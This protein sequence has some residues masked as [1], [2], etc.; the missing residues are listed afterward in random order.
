MNWTYYLAHV[1]S[2]VIY[3]VI[4]NDYMKGAPALT[5]K[6]GPAGVEGLLEYLYGTALHQQ[7]ESWAQEG[8]VG[9]TAAGR[10]LGWLGGVRGDHRFRE[11]V[12]R[13]ARS[14]LAALESA[15]G[16]VLTLLDPRYPTGLRQVS[17]PPLAVHVQGYSQWAHMLAIVGSRKASD[18][19]LRQCFR[20]GQCLSAWG[21]PIVSGGAY[22]CD[23]AAHRG[24]LASAARPCPAIV[25]LAGGLGHLYPAAHEGTFRRILDEGGVLMSERL[26]DE[27]SRPMD[28]PVR[29][30]IVAGLA[31][32]VIVGQCS[33]K[34]GAMITVRSALDAGRDV[35]VLR[36]PPNDVQGLGNEQLAGDG[37]MSFG[38]ID[39]LAHLLGELRACHTHQGCLSGGSREGH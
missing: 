3:R 12:W 39:E 8:E 30:R 21:F 33:E 22:G 1:L 2:Q 15:R 35:W 26:W 13:R 11:L 24:V 34:S 14:N 6:D 4:P 27:P 37:A 20:M 25:V 18:F 16:E 5:P 9:G 32:V 36:H 28:F 17:R 7:Q 31:E 19:A 29:N 10:M 38:D 23:I